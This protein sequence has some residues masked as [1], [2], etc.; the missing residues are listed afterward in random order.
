MPTRALVILFNAYL[1][2]AGLILLRVLSLCIFRP[3]V[4]QSRG[5]FALR[6]LTL[7]ALF[8]IA[9]CTKEGRREIARLLRGTS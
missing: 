5:M 7:A 9:A 3:Q 6:G 1:A 4:P 2:I 8:P